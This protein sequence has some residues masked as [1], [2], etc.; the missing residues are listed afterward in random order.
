MSEIIKTKICGLFREE[1]IDYVNQFAPLYEGGVRRTGGVDYIGF[2]FAPSKRIVTPEQA[3]RLRKR[4]SPDIIPV[5]VFVDEPL[6]LRQELVRNGVID[7]IQTPTH[8]GEYLL[9]DGP[10]PGS[11]QTFDWNTI[12]KTDKPFFL[13]GGLTPENVRQAIA[14]AAPYGVDVSS[15][16]ETNGVKDYDKIKAFIEMSVSHTS[17]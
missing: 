6:E 5:G 9:F 15:G 10:K 11:G 14:I 12:P 7:V 2:V 17:L 1:D 8:I 13:A 3:L 4:L 16:V